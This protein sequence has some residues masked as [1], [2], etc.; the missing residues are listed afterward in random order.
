MTAP[1]DA[2]LIAFADELADAAGEIVRRYFRRG[3]TVDDKADMSPVT[4]ADREAEAAL[5]VLIERRFPDHGILGEE[6]GSVRTGAERVW[7]LD[8]IDGTKSFISGVPLFG[9]LIALVEG[10]VPVLGVIDQPISRERWIGA[11][12]HK[13]A[14]NG[15]AIST[16]ACPALGAATLFATTPDM[17]RGADAEAFQRLKSAVKLAR[18]GGDCYAYGLLAAGFVDLVVEACLKPYDYAALVPV[19]VGAGGSMT[20]WQGGPL[21]LTSDGRVLACGDPRLAPAARGV[22][23]GRA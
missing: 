2:A 11:R 7:V 23:A 9:T 19:I 17:F 15:A 16:R 1:I 13:S 22:L 12:G 8:P 20:D 6:H 14:L 4:I 21:G 5:R 10:G 18:F 3:V